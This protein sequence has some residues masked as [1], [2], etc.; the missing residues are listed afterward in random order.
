[1]N[2]V[3]NIVKSI[4]SGT[5]TGMLAG[6]FFD[7]D[8]TLSEIVDDP[9]KAV[10]LEGARACLEE[11]SKSNDMICG[12]ISGRSLS[13]LRERVGVKGIIYSG[14]HG[15]QID[16]M[17]ETFTVPSDS[18][19]LKELSDFAKRVEDTLRPIKGVFVEDK[20]FSVSVHSRR[21]GEKDRGR[22]EEI[23]GVLLGK[24]RNL[25]MRRGKMVLEIFPEG[26]TDK[27]VALERIIHSLEEKLKKVV[28]PVYFGDD[29][30]DKYGYDFI[31][32]R[33][34]GVSV[35]VRGKGLPRIKADYF[36]DGPRDVLTFMKRFL[37]DS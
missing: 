9:E 33:G 13:D 2:T 4:K 17:G 30:T 34:A 28:F 12:V 5:E 7:F 14:N 27:G 37:A 20:K 29:F 31:R 6:I 22:V 19:F 18:H 36:L 1:M 26:A 10:L 8:G 15:A 24:F 16:M 11:M 3:S 35:F 21:V 23:V 25:V 32:R